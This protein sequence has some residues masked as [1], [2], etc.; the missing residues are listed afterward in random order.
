LKCLSLWADSGSSTGVD[1]VIQ[2]DKAH[3]KRRYV[4]SCWVKS[5]GLGQSWVGLETYEGLNTPRALISPTAI[6]SYQ[7]AVLE[8]PVSAGQRMSITVSH[9]PFE[10]YNQASRRILLDNVTLTAGAPSN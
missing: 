4:L 2:F 8:L 3:A 6:W 1:A 5:E 9:Y 7:T 10:P